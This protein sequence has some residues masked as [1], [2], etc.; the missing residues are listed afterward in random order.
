MHIDFMAV[1]KKL[2]LVFALS[3]LASQAIGAG[4]LAIDGHR[5]QYGFANNTSSVAQ[6]EQQ[7]LKDC[8]TGCQVVLR[9]ENGCAAYAI[10][11]S[12]ES[13][14]YG[15][16]ALKTATEAEKRAMAACEARGG[17][18]CKVQSSGCNKG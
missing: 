15:W 7:A 1:S 5:G 3:V 11:Q 9:F 10:D 2:A 13:R 6:A 18:S 12:G 16:G 17:K 4:A 14:A 8:G